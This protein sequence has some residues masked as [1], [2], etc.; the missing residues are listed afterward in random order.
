MSREQTGD[1][2]EACRHCIFVHPA[3]ANM[4]DAKTNKEGAKGSKGNEI[5][6]DSS[7][8]TTDVESNNESDENDEIE[9]MNNTQKLDELLRKM[10]K[11][12]KVC[13][14]MKDVKSQIKDINKKV[15]E[16]EPMKQNAVRI[17][18][19]VQNTSEK[20]KDTKQHV[21]N[22]QTKVDD[23]QQQNKQLADQLKALQTQLDNA[24]KSAQPNIEQNQS[25]QKIP[26]WKEMFENKFRRK[27]IIIEGIIEARDE[28][29]KRKV[30]DLITTLEVP[31]HPIDLA[32]VKRVGGALNK[33]RKRPRPVRIVFN[34]TD[35]REDLFKARF[36]TKDYPRMKGVWINEDLTE[37][38]RM[39]RAEMRAIVN[40]A[41]ENGYKATQ[42]GDLIIIDAVKYYYGDL[43]KLPPPLTLENAMTKKT[44]K[45]IGFQTKHSPFSNFYKIAVKFQ[46]IEILFKKLKRFHISNSVI[47]WV[48]NYLTGRLQRTM[49]NG[50]VSEWRDVTFGVPQGSTL[51]PLLFLLFVDDV[52]NLEIDSNCVLYADDIVLYCA[53]N[54]IDNN[55]SVLRK[56]MGKVFDWSNTSRLTIN[57]SKTKVMHFGHKAKKEK[58]ACKI[59]E[60]TIECVHSY[61]YLGFLL[62][63]EL[64][65]KSDLKQTT[66]TISQKF[67]MFKKIKYF[68]TKKAKLDVA[69]AMLLSYFTYGNIFYGICNEEDR[70]DL[71]K[72]QNSILRSALEINNPRDISTVNLHFETNT[73]LLDKRRKLQLIVT[74]YKAVNNNSIQLKEN[75]RNLRMF[76]GLVVELEHPNTT[77]FM[78]TPLYLGGELWNNLP[79]NVRNMQDIE[80]FKCAVRKLL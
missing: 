60:Y 26:E 41:N 28:N 53:N 80:K 24:L 35:V 76:D 10:R 52:I 70:G 2:A 66:R 72:L 56:D 23:M 3:R 6:G 40:Y 37:Q 18:T 32:S 49:V 12:D 42:A 65:F 16:I 64:T 62:D 74:I 47:N 7:K 73:L 21:D 9:N 75:V 20:L 14:D 17:E 30:I 46:G 31:I 57:F 34:N 79:A 25:N 1:L 15:D 44:A 77:K 63:Q 71:Q 5:D 43:H 45:G 13:K 38:T 48:K 58:Q 29:I 19:E 54:T 68:L 27:N 8:P 39:K 51:G 78:R 59:D 69:K 55:L 50:K 4:N 61:R 11:I 36:K 67:Y 33:N 22:L